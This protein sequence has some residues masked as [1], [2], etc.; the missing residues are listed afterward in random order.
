MIPRLPEV[1]L[2]RP[3]AHR[4]LHDIDDGRPE[5]SRAAIRAAIAAGYGIEID[6]Q[7]TADDR[8]VVF[9]D[10]ELARLTGAQGR[11]RDRTQ[12]DLATIPLT[13]GTEG[14]PSLAEVLDLVAGQ[15]PLLVE[16][17]D[18]DGAMGA[19]VGVLEAAVAEALSAYD[20]PVAVMSFNPHAV[21]AMQTLAPDLPRGLVTCNF[22]GE[23]T[24]DNPAYVTALTEISDFARVGAAFISHDHRDLTRARVA[25]LKAEG[26]RILT[27]TIR[28][29]EEETAARSMAENVTFEGYLP[30][31]PA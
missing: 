15:V 17:K 2:T 25:Q 14:I 30:P 31:V 26:A 19:D 20:G 21:S 16:I 3:L 11:L 1:F 9:H 24:G 4:G 10:Y 8:A 5:N 18:Q 13:G 28:S 7:L 29:P 12:A 23:P 27:W 22:E 6:V